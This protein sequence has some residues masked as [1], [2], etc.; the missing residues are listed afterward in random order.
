MESPSV[1]L[2]QRL[3]K[4]LVQDLRERVHWLLQTPRLVSKGT[5]TVYVLYSCIVHLV[6]IQIH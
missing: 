6:A 3:V 1:T 5:V 4:T 2:I